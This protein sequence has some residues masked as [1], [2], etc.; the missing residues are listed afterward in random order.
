MKSFLYAVKNGE[1]GFDFRNSF[2]LPFHCEIINIWIG[3]EISFEIIND[4]YDL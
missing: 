2:F 4:P 1:Q 3:R